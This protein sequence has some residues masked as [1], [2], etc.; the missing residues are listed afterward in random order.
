MFKNQEVSKQRTVPLLYHLEQYLLPYHHWPVMNLM[1]GHCS[2]SM[3]YSNYLFEKGR[4]STSIPICTKKQV[5]LHCLKQYTLNHYVVFGKQRKDISLLDCAHFSC[6]YTQSQLVC[7]RYQCTFGNGVNRN[8]W[9]RSKTG[10]HGDC[11]H[12]QM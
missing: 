8:S 4:Y 2:L 5:T 11:R 10:M 3:I 6:S 9:L 7:E 1:S 12:A